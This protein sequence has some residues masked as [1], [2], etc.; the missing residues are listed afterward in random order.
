V[1]ILSP[2]NVNLVFF[3]GSFFGEPF[4]FFSFDSLIELFYIEASVSSVS[5]TVLDFAEEKY[6][7]I[8]FCF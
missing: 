8:L 7:L 5:S 1:G 4:V 6:W 3:L 2:L